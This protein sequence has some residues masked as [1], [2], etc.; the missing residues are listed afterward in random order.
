MTYRDREKIAG[1]VR[2]AGRR[3]DVQQQQNLSEKQFGLADGKIYRRRNLWAVLVMNV[4]QSGMLE[5]FDE[6]I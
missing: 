5:N 4:K 6:H 3:D 1:Q 2:Q